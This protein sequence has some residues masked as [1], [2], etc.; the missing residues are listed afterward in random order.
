ATRY[1]QRPNY[2]TVE[3]RSYF[4]IFDS[5]FFIREL[6][7]D[8]ASEAIGAARAWLREHGHRDI[9]LAAIE[10]NSKALGLVKQIGFDSVTHYVFLPDWKGPFRQ[11][12]R[13]YA[14]LRADQWS[15][16]ATASG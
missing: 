6:G 8:R 11:D 14:A 5:S 16:F 13:H 2:L 10:P 12:Y 1:F 15:D 9:H 4:S 7:H 3:G